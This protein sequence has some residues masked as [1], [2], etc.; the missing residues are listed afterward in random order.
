MIMSFIIIA[1][2]NDSHF[3]TDY[4]HQRTVVCFSVSTALELPTLYD[5]LLCYVISSSDIWQ[6]DVVSVY[7]GNATCHGNKDFLYL[8]LPIDPRYCLCELKLIS[9]WIV[10]F[11]YM[12]FSYHLIIFPIYTN[13]KIVVSYI[14]KHCHLYWPVLSPYHY[15]Y[16]II[17]SG[18]WSRHPDWAI[19]KRDKC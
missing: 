10:H 3:S 2:I 17:Q 14:S 12:S 15:E 18:A 9:V 5:S 8:Y 7:F 1:Y 4:T 16:I 11:N 6:H 19:G 13:D